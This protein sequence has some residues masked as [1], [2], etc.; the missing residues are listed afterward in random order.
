MLGE[1][2]ASISPRLA[3]ISGEIKTD[4]HELLAARSQM[5]VVISFLPAIERAHAAQ[6]RST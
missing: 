4:P 3:R 1:R 5:L 6:E 2:C